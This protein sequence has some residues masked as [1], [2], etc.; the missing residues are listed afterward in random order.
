MKKL[1]AIGIMLVAALLVAG[2]P[3]Q[4][5]TD[6]MTESPTDMQ[7]PAKD[8][9]DKIVDVFNVDVASGAQSVRRKDVEAAFRDDPELFSAVLADLAAAPADAM[10]AVAELFTAEH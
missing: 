3:M 10:S 6:A 4:T 2:C 9:I 8:D 7:T 5:P 1:K